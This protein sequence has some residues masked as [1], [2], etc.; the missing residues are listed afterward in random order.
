MVKLLLFENKAKNQTIRTLLALSLIFICDMVY[1]LL[2]E[3]TI[4]RFLNNKFAYFNV[5]IT[6]ALVFGVSLLENKE[7]THA[8]VNDYAYYG[9][10]IGLLVYVPLY[11]WIISLGAITNFTNLRSLSNTLFGVL[12]S[13]FICVVV[14]LIS[15]KT[16]MLD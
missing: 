16:N 5:W 3:K 2:S 4:W 10:L 13:S 9:I 8:S 6:I 14:F 1:L 15:E 12:S 7:V 11:N